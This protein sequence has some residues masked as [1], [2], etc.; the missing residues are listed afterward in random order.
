M[1]KIKFKKIIEEAAWD[2][3]FGKAL[4][5]LED[6]QKAYNEKKPKLN[7]KEGLDRRAMSLL[8]NKDVKSL[9]SACDGI[10]ME[11]ADDGYDLDDVQR[12][13]ME[14]AKQLATDGYKKAVK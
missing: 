8:N 4:P 7:M 14:Y 1:S 3:K 6:V 11:M 13:V 12:F 10:A 2:K 9:K 5:T